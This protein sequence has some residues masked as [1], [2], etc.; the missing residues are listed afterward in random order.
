MHLVLYCSS[1]KKQA[2]LELD[3]GI[4]ETGMEQALAGGAGHHSL[5]LKPL[6]RV[7]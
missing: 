6:S 3:P 5:S 2:L 4:W 7:S 1:G